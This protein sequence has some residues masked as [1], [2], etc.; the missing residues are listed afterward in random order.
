MAIVAVLPFVVSAGNRRHVLFSPVGFAS[1]LHVIPSYVIGGLMLAA[2]WTPDLYPLIPVPEDTIP[3]TLGVV[4]VGFLSLY[5]GYWSPWAAALGRRLARLVPDPAWPVSDTV[6][7]AAAMLGVGF[8]LY[9]ASYT[10]GIVGYQATSSPQSLTAALALATI[11]TTATA[12]LL[13]LYPVVQPDPAA[14]GRRLAAILLLTAWVVFEFVASGRRGALLQ[15]SVF[16]AGVW[17]CAGS[18]QISPRRLV[19][20][21]AALGTAVLLGMIYG[22]TLR[23][24]LGGEVQNRS[25]ASYAAAAGEAAGVVLDRGVTGNLLYAFTHLGV[26]IEIV[27]SIAVVIGNQDRLAPFEPAYGLANNI[28]T[29]L[30]SSLI[31]RFVWPDKPSVSDPRALGELYFGYRNSYAVTPAADLY[32]NF[33]LWGVVVGMACLGLWLRALYGALM[34]NRPP[35]VM[36]VTLY[37]A[38]LTTVSYEGFF[39][40]LVPTLLRTGAI[41]TVLLVA[42]HV[43]VAGTANRRQA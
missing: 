43:A 8:L 42:V 16:A 28:T 38:L 10:Q 30:M 35:S 1:W 7:A 14:R 26:R 12:M 19:G 17:W 41:V 39:G 37:L 31:P 33:G 5:A 29:S 40:S 11:T 27:T 22:T 25:V 24:T 2:G 6:P 4:G 18:R 3:L 21:G 15:F 20:L 13:L 9:L 23:A 36:R 34:E 32:R